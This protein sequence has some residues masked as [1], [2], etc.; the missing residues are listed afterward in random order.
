MFEEVYNRG[1]NS[2]PGRAKLMILAFYF[3]IFCYMLVV[4]IY[5]LSLYFFHGVL[6]GW[7]VDFAGCQG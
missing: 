6:A 5:S 1:K 3:L 2:Q 7:V 4:Y